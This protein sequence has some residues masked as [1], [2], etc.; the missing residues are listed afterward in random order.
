MRRANLS[1]RLTSLRELKNLQN[2]WIKNYQNQID[3]LEG[4]VANIK[5]IS[6]ALPPGCFKRQRLEP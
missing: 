6:D 1:D 3:Q 2:Q 5:L 4:E